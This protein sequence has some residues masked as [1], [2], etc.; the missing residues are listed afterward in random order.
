MINSS[1]TLPE[2]K[3]LEESTVNPNQDEL[4]ELYDI[5]G[6]DPADDY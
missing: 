2:E 5:D 1:F 6:F 4:V 3:I